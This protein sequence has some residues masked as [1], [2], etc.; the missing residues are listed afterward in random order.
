MDVRQLTR[1]LRLAAKGSLVLLGATV[2]HAG[3]RPHEQ[4]TRPHMSA[5]CSPNW[6]FNQTCWS[7]FPEVPPCQGSGCNVGPEGY[8]NNPSQ[9]MLYSPQNPMTYQNSQIVSPVYGSSQRPISVLP[10]SVQAEVDASSGGMSTMPYAAVIAIACRTDRIATSARAA[11]VGSGA[12]VVATKHEF[13]SKSATDDATCSR[14]ESST[15]VRITVWNRQPL[16]EVSTDCSANVSTD[17]FQIVHKHVSEQQ[18]YASANN[19]FSGAWRKIWLV[20]QSGRR[21][22]IADS[23]FVR[24]SKSCASEI[25]RIV[26]FV[27]LWHVDASGCEFLSCRISG[28]TVANDSQLPD[29]ACRATPEYAIVL[30]TLSHLFLNRSVK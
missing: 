20:R 15:S 17:N 22:D 21:A 23:C 4:P 13:Q 8:E 14:V 9:Q 1:L 12:F 5:T 27:S 30:Q 10:D 7:R 26:N 11:N 25:I 6:G 3:D 18:S 2:V 29:D 24:V 16:D 19:E 28:D